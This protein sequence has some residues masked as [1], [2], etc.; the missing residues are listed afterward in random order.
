M[1][2]K[3]S[4]GNEVRS[5]TIDA[6]DQP[7]STKCRGYLLIL[8]SIF[9]QARSTPE[10]LAMHYLG[11]RISYREFAYWIAYARKF[12]ADQDL[13][14]GGIAVFLSVAHRLDAWA[15]DFALRSLGIHTLAVAAP[16]NLG[17]LDL[18]NVACVITPILGKI[19]DM[20]AGSYKLVRIPQAL[21]LGK[22][23]GAAPEMPEPIHPEGGH[24]LLTSGTTG[25]RKKVLIDSAALVAMSAARG[26]VYGI[27]ADSLVDIFDSAMW[28]GVGYK[29][30]LA[31][32][33]VGG[34]MIF[35]QNDNYHRSLQFDG[36]THAVIT[37]AKLAEVLAA[38]ES[39]LQP[40]PGMLLAVGGAPLTRQ[41]AETARTR[42]TPRLYT[43][44]A[45]TEA[46]IWGLTRIE[47]PDDLDA[48][49]I[50]PSAE[51]QVVDDDDR[52]LPVGQMGVIRVRARNA[53]SGYFEDA[54]ATSLMFRDGYFYPG[55]LGEFRADGRLV[56]HG[57]ASSVIIFGGGKMAAEPIE[58]K[59]QD[60][61]CIE[62]ACLLSLPG[63]LG[64]DDV[65]LILQSRRRLPRAELTAA[66]KSEMPQLLPV[67]VH[68]IT[69][70]PRN[71]MGKI[72]RIILRRRILTT[73]AS[74]IG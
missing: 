30:P 24:I 70:M 43:C 52:P 1:S 68:F 37:P 46:G 33:L 21:Y 20:P 49:Q 65:H 63:E 28:T 29:I 44:L 50:H 32:W 25:V 9:E 59:L 41:L 36:I 47:G 4:R 22:T 16:E 19:P 56:L 71:D 40:N 54:A 55:D 18:R 14:P 74:L 15:L 53:V 42:I 60:R 10:K 61:L 12:F 5:N 38:P 66:V 6:S 2:L 34:A 58:Q 8:K 11:Y 73:P 72:D 26:A 35:H 23:A 17:I 13:P 45:S 39:E 51:V 3:L 67:T 62:A 7:T 69:E 48:H 31:T 27:N 64:K 57:R